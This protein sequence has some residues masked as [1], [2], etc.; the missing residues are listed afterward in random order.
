MKKMLLGIIAVASVAAPFTASAVPVLDQSHVFAPASIA[1]RVGTI[2]SSLNVAVV[3]TFTVGMTGVFDQL[4]IQVDK[5]GT[6][7]QNFVV[8]IVSGSTPMGAALAS[9]TLTPADFATAP[10]FL[11]LD[12]SAAGLLVSTGD[13]L[14]FRLTSLQDFTGNVNEYRAYGESNGSYAGGS[15]AHYQN[16]VISPNTTAWDF[17][18]RTFVDAGRPVQVPEPSTLALLGIG[19]AGLATARRRKQA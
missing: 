11:S 8:D 10:T 2:G 3:Q 1:A 6:P 13:F 5:A 4:D 15:G 19:L 12:F 9:R 7:T 17:N 16:G 14:A 18:F